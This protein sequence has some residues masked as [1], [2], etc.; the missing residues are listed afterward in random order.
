MHKCL[1]LLHCNQCLTTYQVLLPSIVI[2]NELFKLASDLWSWLVSQRRI[3]CY[4]LEGQTVVMRKGI[5]GFHFRASWLSNTKVSLCVYV[6]M[7]HCFF[8]MPFIFLSHQILQPVI[9]SA[10]F[11]CLLLSL[12]PPSF[13]SAYY[14]SAFMLHSGTSRGVVTNICTCG[15]SNTSRDTHL[16]A[17]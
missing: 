5:M 4:W 11:F 2:F 6:L 1:N 15:A 7:I 14:C 10:A 3:S 8:S 13:P 9:D 12:S 17:S 16:P